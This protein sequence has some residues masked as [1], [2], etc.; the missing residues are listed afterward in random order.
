MK[1]TKLKFTTNELTVLEANI[2]I[3]RACPAIS[4][5][6][7]NDINA[8][9]PPVKAALTEHEDK[10]SLLRERFTALKD[11]K[12]TSADAL[13]AAEE[14]GKKEMVMLFKDKVE[15]EVTIL[16]A[17]TF[18]DIDIS[19]DKIVKQQDG[20]EATFSYRDAYFTLVELGLIA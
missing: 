13:K 5:A 2:A 4:F 15:I 14:T 11:N 6:L 12:D 18:A 9:T 8:N 10:V 7:A 3:L 16:Q 1:K 20:S 19:G 17:S